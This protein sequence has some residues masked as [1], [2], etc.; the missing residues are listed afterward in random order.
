MPHVRTNKTSFAGGEIAP[1]LLGR[2]DLR[3]YENGARRLRNVFIHP[4]GGVTRR[5]GLRFVDFTPGPG[6][7]I[8]FEFNTEQV[9]LL[10]F[11]D[12]CIDVY[13]QGNRVARL[14]APWT[15][16]QLDHHV[17]EAAVS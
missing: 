12:L 7:L 13:R 3:A 2:G 9:Y 10:V 16:D 17:R 5:H 14:D 6:R 11:S 8:A 1:Q 4:T 15:A